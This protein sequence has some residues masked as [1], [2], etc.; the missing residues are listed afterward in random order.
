MGYMGLEP[1][2]EVCLKSSVYSRTLI[3]PRGEITRRESKQK[4]WDENRGSF[5]GWATV[6][7]L[8]GPTVRNPH[9]GQNKIRT[10]NGWRPKKRKVSRRT[11]TESKSKTHNQRV[12]IVYP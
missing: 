1:S 2:G 10:R 12:E 3:A 4:T 5:P 6:E 9:R 11:W 7:R 8:E